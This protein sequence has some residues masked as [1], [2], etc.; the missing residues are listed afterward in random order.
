MLACCR[1]VVGIGGEEEAAEETGA[2]GRGVNVWKGGGEV[3]TCAWL[4]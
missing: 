1:K 3:A 4:S 2:L